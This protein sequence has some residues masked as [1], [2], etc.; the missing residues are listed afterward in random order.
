MHPA[1]NVWMQSGVY[2]SCEALKPKLVE[3][4]MSTL[5]QL[6][7]AVRGVWATPAGTSLVPS[8]LKQMVNK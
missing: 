3:T 1:A 2:C 4:V 7:S 6:V 8:M 5:G